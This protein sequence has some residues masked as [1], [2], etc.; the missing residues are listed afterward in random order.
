MAR[1]WQ[2]GAE[3]NSSTDGME[4]DL[5]SGTVSVSTTTVRTGTYAWRANPTAG[6]GFWRV[7]VFSSN[8]NSG[9]Y[10]RVYVNIATL[11]G[12]T[13]QL[14]RFS[15]TA[16]AQLCSLR[17]TSTGTLTLNAANNSQVGSASAALNTGTWYRL[18]L[19]CDATNA[20]G[21]I[22]GRIDGV[23]FASGNNT[24]RGSWARI[25]WGAITP[26]S[27]CNIF[28]DDVAINDSSGAAQTSF[29]GSGKIFHLKPNASGDAN[30][31]LKNG[32]SAGDSNNYQLTDEVT[33]NDGTDYV[34]SGV[35]GNSDM[36]NMEVSGLSG[37]DTVN[38]VMVGGR[39]TND[40]FDNQLPARLQIEKTASGTKTQSADIIPSGTT[41]FTNNNT[42]LV[43]PYPVITYTDPDGAA[44]TSTTLDSHQA[45]VT[46]SGTSALGNRIILSTIWTSVD[47][48]P[49]AGGP[50]FMPRPNG[51]PIQAVN[52]A[53]TY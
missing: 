16:N 42:L 51:L 48:T 27:T 1:K 38:V 2:G 40:V 23:S 53:S 34:M 10:L 26:N 29:P 7:H 25:L 49:G 20:T 13:I 24:S 5:N 17:L 32:G 3:L 50:A 11:P 14:I 8:Q 41:Y 36:Y 31:W 21:T 47:Y 52:R 19:K 35:N 9:G 12:T 43:A 18:E 28:F 30:S 44:W 39:L 15:D 45:G 22:D 33:P 4:V 6:T 37:S 46:I